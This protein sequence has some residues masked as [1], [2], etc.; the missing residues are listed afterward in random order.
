MDRHRISQSAIFDPLRACSTEDRL[1]TY[2]L[3]AR[4]A[5]PS[6]GIEQGD[7]LIIEPQD[8]QPVVLQREIPADYD[9]IIAAADA[10]ALTPDNPARTL[11]HLKILLGLAGLHS[12]VLM[13]PTRP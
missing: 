12:N 3:R 11:K 4:H 7:R 8:I 1:N 10:G 5:V 2:V 6:L 9:A 13:F